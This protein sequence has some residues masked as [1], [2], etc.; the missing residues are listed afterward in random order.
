MEFPQ[1]TASQASP[2]LFNM[3]SITIVIECHCLPHIIK[4]GSCMLNFLFHRLH[5]RQLAAENGPCTVVN[6]VNHM[7]NVAHANTAKFKTTCQHTS[8]TAIVLLNIV[9]NLSLINVIDGSPLFCF[10]FLNL[11]SHAV[12]FFW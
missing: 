8:K 11:D 3:K 7:N 2:S 4:G 5:P 6:R 10:G 9:T 12:R 1:W